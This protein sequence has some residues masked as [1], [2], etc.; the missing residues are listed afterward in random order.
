MVDA[1]NLL[2]YRKQFRANTPADA[3]VLGRRKARAEFIA[4]AYARMGTHGIAVGATDLALGLPLL[5]SVARAHRLPLLS[6]NLQSA[7]GKRLFPANKIVTVGGVKIGIFGLTGEKN[8]ARVKI[9]PKLFKLADPAKTAQAQVKELRAKGA[10]LVIALA[11][12]GHQMGR[13]VGEAA[14]GVDFLFVSGTGR[15]GERASR[16]G[17]SWMMEM[18]REGKYIGHLSLYLRGGK[19][20][21]Q[22]LS[23]RY[24]IANRLARV[25]KSIMG[26]QKRLAKFKG[27]NKEYMQ[28]RMQ[29]SKNSKLRMM[30]QLAKANKV[31]PKGSFFTNVMQPVALNL[32]RE[33]TLKALLNKV[34]KDAGLK[35]PRGAN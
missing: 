28:R 25:N 1:G 17:T 16:V 27:R 14:K 11:A 21:F 19:L 30:V 29:N 4:Q 33:P 20:Q 2:L 23:E 22:D 9:D 6:A 7:A 32:T 31:Q 34:A 8:I 35:R 13:K 15:H 24:Q 5:Q 3:A 10:Q 18:S 12:V 26:L